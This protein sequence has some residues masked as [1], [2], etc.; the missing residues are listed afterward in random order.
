M[1]EFSSNDETYSEEKPAPKEKKTVVVEDAKSETSALV[2][3]ESDASKH[4]GCKCT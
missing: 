4:K 3:Q 2:E 1:E